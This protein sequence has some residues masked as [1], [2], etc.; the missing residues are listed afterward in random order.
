MCVHNQKGACTSWHQESETRCSR[1][2]AAVLVSA[3][4]RPPLRRDRVVK[5]GQQELLLLPNV[6]VVD[7]KDAILQS[8]DDATMTPYDS[9]FEG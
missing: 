1:V 5:A 6:V 7:Q 4:K 8:V 2:A 9:F 3:C